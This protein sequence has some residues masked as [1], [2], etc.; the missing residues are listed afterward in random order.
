MYGGPSYECGGPN[1][2]EVRKD[3]KSKYKIGNHAEND[4]LKKIYKENLHNSHYII[5]SV[6]DE[7]ITSNMM[8]GSWRGYATFGIEPAIIANLNKDINEKIYA[9]IALKSKLSLLVNHYLYKPRGKR[10]IQLKEDF[11]KR[12]TS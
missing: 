8:F 6:I 3:L 4:Y 5:D 1:F 11:E 9:M 10:T 12:T 2:Q 7:Q